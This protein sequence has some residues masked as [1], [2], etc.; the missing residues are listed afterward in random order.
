MGES[1]IEEMLMLLSFIVALLA[2]QNDF[3]V[4][5]FIVGVKA[6]FDFCCVIFYALKEI[7][8]ERRQ[9]NTNKEREEI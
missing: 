3:K 7:L 6:C 1:K 5:A 4:L 2:Y 8:A 9:N